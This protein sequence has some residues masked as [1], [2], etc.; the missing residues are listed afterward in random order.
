MIF[1]NQ[2]TV[3]KI[4]PQKREN[5][6]GVV[7]QA[8][9]DDGQV[10][11]FGGTQAVSQMSCFDLCECSPGIYID[12]LEVVFISVCVLQVFI[13]STGASDLQMILAIN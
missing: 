10:V 9:T 2:K 3:E 13:S 6:V 7:A 8:G 5:K 4:E 1:N 11:V 12:K